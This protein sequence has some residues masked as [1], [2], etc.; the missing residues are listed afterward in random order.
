[1]SGRSPRWRYT[2]LLLMSPAL[3]TG[4]AGAAPSVPED[5]AE[6]VLPS[7]TAEAE[8]EEAAATDAAAAEAEALVYETIPPP[9]GGWTT[10]ELMSVT[11]FCDHRL[12]YPLTMEALGEDFSLTDYSMTM[13]KNRLTPAS[14][15][16]KGS[17]L[18]NATVVKPHDDMMIY[19][20][21]I[22]PSSC[23]VEGIDSFV[24]NGVPMGAGMEETLAALGEDYWYKT[25]DSLLYFDRE[26]G[27]DLYSLFFEND[28]LVHINVA[29]RFEIDLP[30]YEKFG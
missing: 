23:E 13:A 17:R 4:C 27:E 19:N 7:E 1:M 8:P 12:T 29:F 26:T 28:Q 22:L 20:V 15:N 5:A 3:L 6:A 11:Y 10:E 24:I 2:V 30:L 9:E 21:V 25:E 16:Y 18:A 14:L